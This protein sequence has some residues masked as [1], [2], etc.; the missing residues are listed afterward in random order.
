MT[1]EEK[2]EQEARYKKAGRIVKALRWNRLRLTQD[3]LAS[4]IGVTQSA[5]SRYEKGKI[6]ADGAAARYL[7]LQFLMLRL[8]DTEEFRELAA[9]LGVSLDTL[10]PAL[11]GESGKEGM[12][13][14]ASRMGATV[15]YDAPVLHLPGPEFSD[16]TAE[17]HAF[18]VDALKAY[19][20]LNRTRDEWGFLKRMVDEVRAKSK[21]FDEEESSRPGTAAPKGRAPKGRAPQL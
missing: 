4:A 12:E 5:I 15:I 19:R 8:S 11:P 2:S 3:G 7:L 1:D 14:L 6:P 9:L 13:R 20:Y 17:E 18:L 16:C 10:A 21:I